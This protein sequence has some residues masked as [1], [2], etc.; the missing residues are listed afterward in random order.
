MLQEIISWK[1]S[2]LLAQFT[3]QHRLGLGSSVACVIMAAKAASYPALEIKGMLCLLSN[4]RSAM[5]CVYVSHVKK[6]KRGGEK[7]K[8]ESEVTVLLEKCQDSI[9]NIPLNHKF[10]GEKTK[11]LDFLN[12]AYAR[13]KKMY[14][15]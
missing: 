6:K 13:L 15:I 5:E 4:I 9:G 2:H 8:R 7:K 12:Y 1:K 11:P 3:I 10:V 14:T